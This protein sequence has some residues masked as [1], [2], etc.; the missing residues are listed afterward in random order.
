MTAIEAPAAAREDQDVV[1]DELATAMIE[2]LHTY[3]SIKAK[4]TGPQADANPVFLLAK[5]VH[6]GPRRSGE[7]ATH[8]CADPST[9]SRQVANLVKQGL[10]ERQ[11][12]PEDGRASLLVPTPSGVDRV[13]RHRR[14]RGRAVAP[15]VA[16]WAPE[17]VAEFTRLLRRYLVGLD[18]HRDAIVANMAGHVSAADHE[19][20][21]HR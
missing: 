11:A 7:L 21:D 14:R 1:L 5:L 9:V 2:L 18:D 20:G 19:E 15:V 6:D 4:V 8:L 13:E 10:V 16:D 12:D 17:D 3:G